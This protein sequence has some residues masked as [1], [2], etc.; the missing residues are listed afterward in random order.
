MTM[1]PEDALATLTASLITELP[2]L[3]SLQGWLD[4]FDL[5]ERQIFPNI[6]AT[7]RLNIEEI[8]LFQQTA[9]NFHNIHLRYGGGP[10]RSIG[11]VI[12]HNI[13]AV[14]KDGQPEDTRK[15]LFDIMASLAQTLAKMSWHAGLE[16][17][18]QDYFQLALHA[19]H[20]TRN[21]LFD[22]KIFS[23]LAWQ[24]YHLGR[25]KVALDLIHLAQHCTFDIAGPQVKAMLYMHEAWA[26][27][28]LGQEINFQRKI[29]LAAK[30]ITDIT[31]DEEP[32][33][34]KH[35][36]E[37]QLASMTA[38]GIRLLAIHKPTQFAEQASELTSKAIALRDEQIN[39]FTAQ[40]YI[41]FAESRL[42]LK[43]TELAVGAIEQALEIF[44][45]LQS[46]CG[47]TRRRLY[48]IFR[49]TNQATKSR[50]LK[51]VNHKI[52]DVLSIK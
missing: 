45:Q 29:E 28:A 2:I 51:K 49:Y 1:N 16:W 9:I 17:S 52:K 19:I 22:A 13:S 31:H 4:A 24:M 42:L 26:Y 30:S 35:Y 23:G 48:D 11:K 32:Y 20:E 33:W 34:V 5:E 50:N 8:E 14:L 25:P 12:L 44:L 40:D 37:S 3:S 46:R 47:T 10:S 36:D 38:G 15:Q 39:R 41:G 7:N 18:A 6:S 27:A 21:R 43:D